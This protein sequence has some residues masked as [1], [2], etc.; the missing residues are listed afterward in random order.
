MGKLEDLPF[1][2]IPWF[3][4]ERFIDS[5]S[6]ASQKLWYANQTIKNGWSR[7]V[8]MHQIKSDLYQ[9]QTS[10][11]K[12]HNFDLTLPNPQSELYHFHFLVLIL[13]NNSL[14]NKAC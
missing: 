6:E 1:F 9:R 5:L 3:I 12:T 11:E 14:E 7:N 4:I 13:S 10:I 2:N 8:L